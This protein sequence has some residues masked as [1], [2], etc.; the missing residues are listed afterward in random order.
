[1]GVSQLTQLRVLNLPNNSIGYIE[2]LRDLQNL[3][4][5]NLS[6]NNIKVTRLSHCS[7]TEKSFKQYIHILNNGVAVH[8]FVYCTLQVIEQLN[9]CVSLQH[10]DLSDNNISS[11][12][13]LS[14]L[15]ALKVSAGAS[16]V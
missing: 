4:W 10:L 15:V 9:N 1:M 14:K 5:L 12:G 16:E 11:I 13:D 8:F 6:G 7:Y 3:E 2:G